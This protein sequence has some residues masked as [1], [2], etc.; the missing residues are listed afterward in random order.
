MHL[1]PMREFRS[2]RDAVKGIRK[3]YEIDGPRRKCS[4]LVSIAW[5]Q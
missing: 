3:E 2:I 5:H 4:D 1:P